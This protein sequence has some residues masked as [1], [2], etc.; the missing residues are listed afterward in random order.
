MPSVCVLSVCVRVCVCVLSVCLVCVC[1]LS[2]LS[3]CLLWCC[4]RDCKPQSLYTYCLLLPNKP[5]RPALCSSIHLAGHLRTKRI[6]TNCLLIT[7]AARLQ[8]GHVSWL[9]LVSESRPTAAAR[10]TKKAVG[11]A[12]DHTTILHVYTCQLQ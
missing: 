12:Q 5:A 6:F 8:S 9:L 4:S 3:V 1:V 7:A 10:A 11:P 2:V